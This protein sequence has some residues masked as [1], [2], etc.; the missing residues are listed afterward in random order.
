MYSAIPEATGGDYCLWPLYAFFTKSYRVIRH[1]FSSTTAVNSLPYKTAFLHFLLIA[2]S[3]S[4]N[5]RHHFRTC[6]FILQSVTQILTLLDRLE[7]HYKTI[8]EG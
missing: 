8:C 6:L 5:I 2:F 1:Y 7:N 3:A 4:I